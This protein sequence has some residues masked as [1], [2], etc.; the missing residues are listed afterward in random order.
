MVL[1]FLQ[2]DVEQKEVMTMLQGLTGSTK[3]IHTVISSCSAEWALILQSV[4][5]LVQ[6]QL[7]SQGE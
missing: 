3:T 1:V 7:L 5:R 6:K 4:P 2:L